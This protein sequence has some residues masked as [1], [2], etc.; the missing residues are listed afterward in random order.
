MAFE[1]SYRIYYGQPCLLHGCTL[2]FFSFSKGEEEKNPIFCTFLP[3]Y[4]LTGTD[5]STTF[6]P[7]CCFFI[8]QGLDSRAVPFCVGN[9]VLFKKKVN[10]IP[11]SLSI[12]E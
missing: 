3:F 6:Y 7:L 5:A 11:L 8:F 9:D 10:S 12:S 1:V 4:Q 2:F